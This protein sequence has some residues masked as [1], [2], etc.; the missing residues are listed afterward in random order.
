MRGIR[1]TGFS[2]AYL[3]KLTDMKL[4]NPD[5]DITGEIT[6]T[7]GINFA[8]K[9]KLIRAWGN[10]DGEGTLK[11]NYTKRALNSASIIGDI[12]MGEAGKD[13]YLAVQP[14]P[15][16]ANRFVSV[17]WFISSTE[18]GTIDPDSGVVHVK[19]TGEEAN[20]PS[21]TVTCEITTDTGDVI[22]AKQVIG[23]YVRSCKVGDIVFCDG[24]YSDVMDG[25]KTPVGVCFYIN[26][27]NKAE[28]LCMGLANLPSMPWGLYREASNGTNG[29]DSITLEDRPAYNCFDI[30][31]IQNITSRGLTTDYITEETYRDE[32][33][34]GD[35]DGYR[36]VTGA[37]GSIGF[38]EATEAIGGYE[39]GDKLPIGLYNT[40]RI[41]AHRDI[42]INDPTFDELPKPGDDGAGLYQSLINCIAAANTIAPEVPTVLL[43]GCVPV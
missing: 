30:P 3:E 36:R 40:L 11:I 28:R 31:S 5:C 9:A 23:F 15:L 18:Y 24:T 17:K 22:T 19:K 16:N 8:L 41:I 20:N 33:S 43:P 34:A 35:A 26:P 4:A 27:E 14:D 37:A 6:V 10:V 7:G 42:I 29:F 21:A 38:T 39:R 32:S 12:Y 2:V 1:W 25:S 13:Y